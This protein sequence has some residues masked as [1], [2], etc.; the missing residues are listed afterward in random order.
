M[1]LDKFGS[2]LKDVFRKIA[3]MGVVDKKAVESIMQDVQRTLLMADVDVEM[4]AELSE[5]IKK[6]VLGEQPP[7][8]MSLREYFI[9]VLYDEIVNF[10]GEE[11]AGIELK[12]QKILVVGLFGSG[13]TTTIGKIAKWFKTR[14]MMPGLV[15]CDTHRPAAQTQ[16]EQIGK[17]VG[18]HVYREG[19]NPV[20]IAKNALKNAKED[21]LLFDSA[22]RDALDRELAEEL[23]RLGEIIKP[24]EV[25]LV[26]PADIG[27][28]ARKQAE[29]FNKL[30][31]IT[32]IVVTKL[33]QG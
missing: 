28:A 31:G 11:K 15:A 7:K 5:R 2:G 30:V 13:K 18:V 16:L 19:K 17:A 22:G 14:G 33:E 26:I 4:V 8:G 9:K 32:G 6:T 24:E 3:R 20:D 23:K 10:L 21:V 29:E 27:Q 25:L 1:V 12:K